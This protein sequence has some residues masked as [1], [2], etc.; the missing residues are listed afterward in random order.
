M[1]SAF[2]CL[3]AE[4]LETQDVAVEA[5]RP[6]DVLYPPVG[7]VC[8]G[9]LHRRSESFRGEPHKSWHRI[10]VD[11]VTSTSGPPNAS[12]HTLSSPF[13]TFRFVLRGPGQALHQ[14]GLVG[15]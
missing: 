15:E 4:R 10:S 3:E 13:T 9:Y 5:Q 12:N 6:L 1:L 14:G 7:V 11:Q 2:K 8:I